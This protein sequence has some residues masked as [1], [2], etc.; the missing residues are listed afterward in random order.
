MN[1]GSDHTSA[2]LVAQEQL[3]KMALVPY[4]SGGINGGPQHE[5]SVAEQQGASSSSSSSCTP[6]K[7]AKQ[8]LAPGFEAAR[9]GDL[10]ALRRIVDSKPEMTASGSSTSRTCWD[11]VTSVDRIHGSTALMW[12]AG[13]GHVDVCRFLVEECGANPL[14]RQKTRRKRKSSSAKGPTR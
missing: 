11:P 2:K 5:Q 13:A 10:G 14:S 9:T 8:A 3:S 6:S 7:K 12:A 1:H 4:C